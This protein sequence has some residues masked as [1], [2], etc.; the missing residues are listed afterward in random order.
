MEK[1]IGD[2]YL[3][4]AFLAYNGNMTHINRNDKNRQKFLF[5]GNVK[6]IWILEDNNIP[7]RIVDPDFDAIEVYFL[8]KKLLFP[9]TYPDCLRRIKSVIHANE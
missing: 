1:L 2:M 4:A 3:A 8:S 5:S 7:V 9:P 6:E